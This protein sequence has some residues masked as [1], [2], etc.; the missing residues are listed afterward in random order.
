MSSALYLELLYSRSAKRVLR[1][2]ARGRLTFHANR[3]RVCVTPLFLVVSYLVPA[4]MTAATKHPGVS[5]GS[6]ATRSLLGNSVMVGVGSGGFLAR[7]EVAGEGRWTEE[8]VRTNPA[9]DFDGPLR[10]VRGKNAEVGSRMVRTKS[11]GQV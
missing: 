3:S 10:T 4:S 11:V 2:A 8:L 6:V 1:Q 9:G 7:K 5:S